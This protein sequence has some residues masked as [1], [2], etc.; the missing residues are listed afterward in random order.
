MVSVADGF[1][2]R[3]DICKFIGGYRSIVDFKTAQQMTSRM[4][5]QTAG[6]KFLHNAWFP[7]QPIE[8]RYGL[9]LQPDGFYKLVP[10]DDLD[11]EKAFYDLLVA[12]QANEKAAFWK[13]KYA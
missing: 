13:A 2:G 9:R 3:P 12:A 5:L 10:H 4:R 7:Y 1:A 6:Y 8:K 11:D